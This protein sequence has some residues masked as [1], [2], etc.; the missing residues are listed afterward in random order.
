MGAKKAPMVSSPPYDEI[1]FSA[2]DLESLCTLFEVFDN[3]GRDE[4]NDPA[5]S[6]FEWANLCDNFSPFN[7]WLCP[8]EEIVQ[9]EICTDE[10]PW[11]NEAVRKFYC[12]PLLANMPDAARRA[13]CET[14]CTNYVSQ[15]RGNCCAFECIRHPYIP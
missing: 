7:H 10:R 8:S 14:W 15:D 4:N 5:I 9:N 3:V 6:G 2:E 13:S 11:L 1:E 12:G